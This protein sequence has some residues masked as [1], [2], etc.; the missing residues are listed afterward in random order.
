M[1]RS[2]ALVVAVAM[3]LTALAGCSSVART[4]TLPT[5]DFSPD[6]VV[7]VH[8]CPALPSVAAKAPACDEGLSVQPASNPL[9]APVRTTP[10]HSVLLVRNLAASARRVTGTVKSHVVFD[11]GQMAQGNTTTVVLGTPG[12]VTITDVT[13]GRHTT[14]TVH[15][16]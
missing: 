15:P 14:L 6:L 1:R 8:P 9:D 2:A 12:V 3:A 4:P 7:E 16:A 13:T 5:T 10:D 11:T